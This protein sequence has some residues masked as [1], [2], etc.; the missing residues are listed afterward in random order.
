M[1]SENAQ[2][3]YTPA[4]KPVNFIPNIAVAVTPH[5]TATFQA[6]LLYVGVGGDVVAMP[7]GIDTFVTFK[8]VP[9]GSFLPVYIKA[10]NTLANGTTATD[11][12]ICY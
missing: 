2:I 1:T 11:M 12:L 4:G 10:V 7:Q 6:G 5:A 3:V 9:E 8:N